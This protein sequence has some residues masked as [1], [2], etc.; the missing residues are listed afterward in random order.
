MTDPLTFAGLLDNAAANAAV[1]CWLEALRSNPQRD[2]P[3]LLSQALQRA[4]QPR[5]VEQH[6]HLA[7]QMVRADR[8]VEA[9]RSDLRAAI[10]NALG[11]SSRAAAIAGTLAGVAGD[12]TF[13][14]MFAED[15]MAAAD[16]ADNLAAAAHQLRSALRAATALTEAR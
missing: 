2:W 4:D 1:N 12:G 16:L 15:V 7:E 5:E 13:D 10:S 14:P 6:F 11:E 8:R 9:L 3:A